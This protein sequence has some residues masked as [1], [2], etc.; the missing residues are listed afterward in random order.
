VSYGHSL[1][2]LLAA[3][4]LLGTLLHHLIA[5]AYALASFRARTADLRTDTAGELVTFRA[6]KHEVGTRAANV[7]TVEQ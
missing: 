3:A 1:A 4:A 5:F 2:R 7:G 6:P